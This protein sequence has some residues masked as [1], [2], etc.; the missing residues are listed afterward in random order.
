MCIRD[1]FISGTYAG[2]KNLSV[3]VSR[4][5][6]AV[7]SRILAASSVINAHIPK[8][9]FSDNDWVLNYEVSLSELDEPNAPA[10]LSAGLDSAGMFPASAGETIPPYKEWKKNV[11][12][13]FDK[14]AYDPNVIRRVL[15]LLPDKTFTKMR[16]DV[17]S[18]EMEACRD[19]NLKSIVLFYKDVNH[20]NL[21]F[22]FDDVRSLNTLFFHGHANYH[23][24]DSDGE[25]VDRTFFQCWRKKVVKWFPD[26]YVKSRAFS[27]SDPA[28]PLP[29]DW[30]EKGFFLWPYN[31]CFRYALADGCNTGVLFDLG[32]AFCA[33][34][35]RYVNRAFLGW[36]KEFFIGAGI[37]EGLTLSDEGLIEIAE[38][39]GENKSLSKALT[40]TVMMSIGVR[41][42]LWGPDGMIDAGL[43]GDDNLRVLPWG[44]LLEIYLSHGY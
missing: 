43:D 6:S 39:L 29:D 9:V 4:N 2:S 28:H 34:P 27:A 38:T 13:K 7:Y 8:E 44:S 32:N 41:K 24:L 12:E 16:W 23:T 5:G 17:I 14:D 40:N 21:D 31:L 18:S 37:W 10:P 1:S 25:Y 30:D 19:R 11:Y 22:V 35:N 15:F 42:E 26:F 33:N 3:T 36:K 20:V